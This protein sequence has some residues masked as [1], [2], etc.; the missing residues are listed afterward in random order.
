LFI[1]WI[2]EIRFIDQGYW[3]GDNEYK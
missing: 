3:W 2:N 1:I